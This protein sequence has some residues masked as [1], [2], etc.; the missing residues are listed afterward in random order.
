MQDAG[1]G[2]IYNRDNRFGRNPRWA[3]LLGG[4]ALAVVAAAAAPAARA[5]LVFQQTNLVTDP[6]PPGVTV[7]LQDPNLINPWGVSYSPTGPFWISDN[8]S[9]LSSIYAVSGTS[10]TIN[11]IPPVTIATPPPPF[12]GLAAPTGQVFV[13][14]VPGAGFTVTGDGKSGQAS[15]LF[16][17]EDGTISG[18][19]F[20]VSSTR[21]FLEVDNSKNGTGA[22]YKGLALGQNGS[23]TLLYASNFRAGAV[24]VY[25]TGFSIVNTITDP[26][27]PKGYAP[28]NVQVLNTV[29][30]PKLFVTFAL[31][32]AA[33]HDDVAGAGHGFIDMFNLDGTGMVRVASRGSLNSP[34]GL[35]IAP[36][37]FGKFAGDLLVGNFGNGEVHAF[38]LATDT[39]AGTLLGTNGKPIDIGDLWA[40]IQGNGGLAG[41]VNDLFFTAGVQDEAH[42]LFGFLAPTNIAVPE[43]ASAGLLLAGLAVLG[44]RLRRGAGSKPA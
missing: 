7:P 22:V 31:Q 44:W 28:F 20:G 37:S 21:S 18:L 32:N 35:D 26:T 24:E 27:V 23:N 33:K 9:G 10:V 16:A 38:N 11:A 14:N 15:F 17:T 1:T 25:N 39:F 13:G 41:D 29:S 12:T 5:E 6:N 34:W 8:N 36:S 40:L 4:T 19:S 42:G 3:A 30:G 2:I 43:P